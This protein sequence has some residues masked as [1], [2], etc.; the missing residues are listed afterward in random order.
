MFVNYGVD[1]GVLI[2]VMMFFGGDCWCFVMMV[3]DEGCRS[4]C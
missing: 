2:L 3:F 1:L 4:G